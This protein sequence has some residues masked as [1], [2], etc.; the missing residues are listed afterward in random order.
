[1]KSWSVRGTM[2]VF[3]AS[4]L[5]LYLHEGRTHFLRPQDK[6]EADEWITLAR[7]QQ[8]AGRIVQLIGQGVTGREQLRAACLAEGLTEREA[9]SVFDPWG[10]TLRYLAETGQI[11]H[12]V[13]EDKAFQ[14]CPPFTPMEEEP[15]RLFPRWA[16]PASADSPSLK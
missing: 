3:A 8:F 7:K 12:K 10:G 9:Q 5:P 6:M 2:H 1:M 14:L 11:T 16:P 4:D 13:G 15:A